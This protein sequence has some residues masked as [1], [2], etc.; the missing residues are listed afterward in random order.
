MRNDPS[1]SLAA[2][3]HL[4][5]LYIPLR[6]PLRLRHFIHYMYLQTLERTNI[7]TSVCRPPLI[8]PL[9]FYSI[10]MFASRKRAHDDDEGDYEECARVIKVN[11]H[12]YTLYDK[13]AKTRYSNA[14]CLSVLHP[15]LNTVEAFRS[16]H[17]IGHR[18]S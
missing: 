4:S 5:I 14:N 18:R 3:N 11:I 8:P 1:S 9:A 6:S 16:Q 17:E 13:L 10:T 12:A 15:P 7:F 2:I